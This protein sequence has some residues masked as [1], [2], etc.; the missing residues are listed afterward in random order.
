MMETPT[1]MHTIFI[2]LSRINPENEMHIIEAMEVIDSNQ[3]S[4][5][6]IKGL[7]KALKSYCEYLRT[8]PSISPK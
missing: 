7:F 1:R 6:L 4:C 2:E 5:D 3:A 8:I